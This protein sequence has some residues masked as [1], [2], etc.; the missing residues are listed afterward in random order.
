MTEHVHNVEVL[1]LSAIHYGEGR[2]KVNDDKVKELSESFKEL[3]QLV[4]VM[5]RKMD[6]NQFMLLAGAH[7]IAA[8][9]LL[10]WTTIH[11]TV[12]DVDDDDAALIEIDENLKRANLS[13][14]E[15]LDLI[16]KRIA[17]VERKIQKEKNEGVHHTGRPGAVSEAARAMGKDDDA[18]RRTL[19]LKEVTDEAWDHA[20]NFKPD[21]DLNNNRT[22]MTKVAK[23]KIDFPCPEGMDPDGEEY[24]SMYHERLAAAQCEFIDAEVDKREQAK[25]ERFMEK[26]AQ[27]RALAEAKERGEE[28]AEK[29]RAPK[30]DETEEYKKAMHLMD[31]M[32]VYI[33]NMEDLTKRKRVA[34]AIAKYVKELGEPATN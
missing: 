14:K 4:P 16:Q 33:V 20:E 5:L 26:E 13:Q 10:N 17:I 19:K 18:V 8:A 9:Q 28:P 25:A 6:G 29:P 21:Y 11:A 34:K 23:I 24:Q 30:I 1:P 15:E 32:R 2:R 3:G 7:R 12:H 22:F 31:A 27:A